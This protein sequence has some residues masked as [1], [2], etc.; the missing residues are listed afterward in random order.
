LAAAIFLQTGPHVV[1]KFGAS[2]PEH[3]RLRANNAVMWAAIRHYAATGCATLD[4]GRTTVGQQGLRRFKLSWGAE[5]T[6]IGYWHYD[7]RRD[8]FVR[9]PDRSMGWHTAFF[10]RLPVPVLRW[11]G[12]RLYP[13][14]T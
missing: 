4:L 8:R 14:L 13:H 12:E 10:R 1:Y 3:L 2:E 7:L 6:P 5:E 11:L 9:Q